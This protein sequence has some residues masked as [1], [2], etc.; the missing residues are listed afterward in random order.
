VA[1]RVQA[2]SPGVRVVCHGS[3]DLPAVEGDENQLETALANLCQNATD[4]MPGGGTLTLSAREEELGDRPELGLAAGRWVRVDVADTGEGMAA[5]VRRRAIEPFFTT[6]APGSAVGLGLS[7]V[8]GVV[9]NHGGQ[10]TIVSEPGAG[11]TV[12]FYLPPA[13]PVPAQE[14]VS[15][16]EG[17]ATAPPAGVVLLVDDDEWI[18]F[19]VGRLLEVLGYRVI[20][21]S[22]G[23]EGLVEYQ[24]HRE[25]IVAVLLDL[26]MPGMDGAEVLER[27]VA[28]DPDVRVIIC[29]GYERDQ[30]SQRLFALG[31][32]GFLRKPFGPE[33]LLDR[34]RTFARRA[35]VPVPEPAG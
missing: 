6:R 4:A 5:E 1:D 3:D 11:T 16:P 9:H 27:L 33:D 23:A 17:A 12:T 25:E 34:L 28:I 32:V 18:R 19:S 26:R 8:Y 31:R 22:G 24:A 30:V 2:K 10:L 13:P 29:T 21:A 7:M 35:P 14:P 20:E 15:G